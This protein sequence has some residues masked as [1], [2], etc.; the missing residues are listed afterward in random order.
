VKPDQP[1]KPID[2]K[3]TFYHRL[4]PKHSSLRLMWQLWKIPKHSLHW[5]W[6]G[7]YGRFP[8]KFSSGSSQV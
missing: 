3:T 8:G 2:L 4:I 5:G 7:S 6:C 1:L